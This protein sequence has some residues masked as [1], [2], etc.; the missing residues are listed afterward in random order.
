MWKGKAN[1]NGGQCAI[2]WSKVCRPVELGGLGIHNLDTLSWS[3]RMRWLWLQKTQPDKPWASLPIQINANAKALFS[4]SIISNVG[5]GNNT[6]FWTDRWLHGRSISDMVPTLVAAVS[7]RHI[8]RRIVADALHN[9]RWIRDISGALSVHAIIEYLQVWDLLEGMELQ[10]GMPDVHTWVH[11]ASGQY[12]SK[13][14]YKVF[15]QGSI[16]FEPWKRLWKSW[17][18]LWCKFFLWL[19]IKNRCWT[20]D[21]LARRGLSHPPRCPLCDQEDETIQ[22]LLTSCVFTR[23]IWFQVLARTGLQQLTP[24]PTDFCF[25]DWWRTAASRA[26]KDRR[27]GLNS[28]IILSAWCIWKHRNECVFD[29]RK[30]EEQRL[31]LAIWDEATLWSMAGAKGLSQLLA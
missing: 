27:S 5:D 8:S 20:A 7:K 22:H 25:S 18:P 31:E 17:A 23:Q 12:S 24:Q 1:A 21:R 10:E 30:P 14:A 4:V 13:S 15:F 26:P 16:G 2:A 29:G 28:L 11:S 3:L 19:A 6:M 9:Q